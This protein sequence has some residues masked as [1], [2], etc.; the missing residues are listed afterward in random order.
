[1]PGRGGGLQL[2]RLYPRSS[3]ASPYRDANEIIN[4]LRAATAGE[5]SSSPAKS[6]RAVAQ[7]NRGMDPRSSHLA[8][9]LMVSAWP[10]SIEQREAIIRD[11][12]GLV[13][14]WED[15]PVRFDD[16]DAHTEALIDATVSR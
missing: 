14:L 3:A 2:C 8:S 13:D 5:P 4:L 15:S 12:G 7:L 10:R 11:G 6:R 1:M 16:N 9:V